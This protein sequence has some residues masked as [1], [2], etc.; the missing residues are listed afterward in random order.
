[1]EAACVPSCQG[2][3]G[4]N[5][6]NMKKMENFVVARKGD[7]SV[8]PSN[9]PAA[10]AGADPKETPLLPNQCKKIN[11]KRSMQKNQCKNQCKKINA[12][13]SKRCASSKL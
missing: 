8:H 5:D 9:H 13:K 11:A 1:M 2:R 6:R 12:K 3:A 10:D 4:T 7:P